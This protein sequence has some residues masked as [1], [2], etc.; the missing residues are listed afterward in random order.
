MM[1][2]HILLAYSKF[3]LSLR[4]YALSKLNDYAVWLLIANAE[5]YLEGSSSSKGT[6]ITSRAIFQLMSISEG[7]RLEDDL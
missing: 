1:F 3:S 7:L 2:S 6:Q 5:L 4:T